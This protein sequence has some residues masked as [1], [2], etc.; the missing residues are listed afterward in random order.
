MS[1]SLWP[2]GLQHA[3]LPCPLPTLGACSNSCPLSQWCH[4]TIS[5]SIIPFSSC[6]QVFTASGS[7]PRSQFFASGGQSIQEKAKVGW[8]ERI[9]LKHVY[10]HMWN[11]WPVQVRCMK[12]GTHTWCSG[13]TQRDGVKREVGVEF[14]TGGTHVHPWLIHVDVWQKPPQYCKVIILQLKKKKRSNGR[15]LKY[16]MLSTFLQHL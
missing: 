16:Q 11:S 9:A 3:R 2:H 7:L 13:T 4:L 12:Q 6:P 8:F 14:R 15:F 10:Y 5:F 1:Y